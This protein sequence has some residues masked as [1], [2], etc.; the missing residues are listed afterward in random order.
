MSLYYD[1]VFYLLVLVAINAI[2]RRIR[3]SAVF[4]PAEL[5]AF[6][7]LMSVA[8]CASG[9]D[10]MSPLMGTIQGVFRFATPENAWD[11]LFLE[12]VPRTMT[13]SDPGALESLWRGDSSFFHAQ[14]YRAWAGPLV[15]WWLFLSALWRDW[16]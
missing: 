14:N 11:R 16:S 2:L 5:L 10:L 12:Y 4:V 15:R 13:V 6:F 7:T 9:H 8:T 3:P 1:A